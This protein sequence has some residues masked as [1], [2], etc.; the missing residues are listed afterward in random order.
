MPHL[1]PILFATAT[2]TALALLATPSFAQKVPADP[3]YNSAYVDDEITVVAPGVYRERTG[4]RSYS[5]IPV[6]DLTLQR[7]VDTYDLN[8]RYDADVE[9]LYRRIDNTVREACDEVERASQGAPITT[10][11]ECIRDARR[12]A[13]AQADALIYARRG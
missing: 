1:R 13:M 11:R 2:A 3:Y 8:L 10:E 6:E 9:E 5:G 4:R 7:V 12:D